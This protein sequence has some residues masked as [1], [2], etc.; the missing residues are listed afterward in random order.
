MS[1]EGFNMSLGILYEMIFPADLLTSAKHPKINTLQPQKQH[2][3]L[4]N[5]VRKLLTNTKTKLNET[6]S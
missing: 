6:K 3:N 4:N 1:C 5:R 2:K